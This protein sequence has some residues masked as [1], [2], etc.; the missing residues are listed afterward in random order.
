MELFEKYG[1]LF[2][3]VC[4][5]VCAMWVGIHLAIDNDCPECGGQLPCDDCFRELGTGDKR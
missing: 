3:V 1:P 4:W 2:M 5:V